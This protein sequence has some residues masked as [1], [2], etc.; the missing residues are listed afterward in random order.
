MVML[1]QKRL[2][3]TTRVAE[4]VHTMRHADAVEYLA[5]I[6]RRRCSESKAGG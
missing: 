6:K 3:L 1:K 2:R 4:E 5:Q